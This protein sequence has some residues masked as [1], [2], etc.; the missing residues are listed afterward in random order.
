MLEVRFNRHGDRLSG[1]IGHSKSG[2]PYL[3]C[4][5][6]NRN[7]WEVWRCDAFRAFD[8]IGRFSPAEFD[9]WSEDNGVH[10]A[11]GGNGVTLYSADMEGVS[12]SS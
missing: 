4:P 8:L 2:Q 6:L 5:K 1:F 11:D 12:T 9:E 10:W 7:R 3:A